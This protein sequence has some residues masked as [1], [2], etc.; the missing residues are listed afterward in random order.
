MIGERILTSHLTV[1][2]SMIANRLRVRNLE[3][4]NVCRNCN[5]SNSSVGTIR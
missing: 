3:L 2:N 5:F 1:S 4:A